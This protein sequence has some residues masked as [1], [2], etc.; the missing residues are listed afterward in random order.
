MSVAKIPRAPYES[1]AWNEMSSM[2]FQDIMLYSQ[3]FPKWAMWSEVNKNYGKSLLKPINMY[4]HH[5]GIKPEIKKISDTKISLIY[6]NYSDILVQIADPPM[7]EKGIFKSNPIKTLFYATDKCWQRQFY[8]SLNSYNVNSE[9]L[10]SERPFKFYVPWVLDIDIEYKVKQSENGKSIKVIE[11]TDRFVKNTD[12]IINEANYI[13]FYFTKFKGH[14]L[15]ETCG[16]I[17]RGT[18]L[19]EIEIDLNE[20]QIKELLNG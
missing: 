8:P 2:S 3:M 16:V 7:G 14:M 13:D 11:K 18:D 6:K 12:K 5:F 15:T 9:D 19:Y 20:E 10:M 17:E 1:A 4:V